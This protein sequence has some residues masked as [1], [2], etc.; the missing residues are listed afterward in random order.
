MRPNGCFFLCHWASNVVSY[1][2]CLPFYPFS[3]LIVLED[4]AFKEKKM[5]NQKIDRVSSLVT[6]IKTTKTHK[7]I[8]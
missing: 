2:V 5:G 3:P 1:A 7:P 4:S 8:K 6:K